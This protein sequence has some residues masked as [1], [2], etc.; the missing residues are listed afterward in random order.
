[1]TSCTPYLVGCGETYNAG[2]AC[3]Q[4]FPEDGE[5]ISPW[6]RITFINESGKE[7][8]AITVGNNSIGEEGDGSVESECS[9]AV[10]KSFVFGTADGQTAEV[11]IHDQKGSSFVQFMKNL[12]KDM[13]CAEPGKAES[14]QVKCSF[15]WVNTFCNGPNGGRAT[16]CD[17]WLWPLNVSTNFAEGK[18]M[19]TITLKDMGHIMLKHHKEDVLK[20]DDNNRVSLVEAVTQLLTEGAPSV[21]SVEFLKFNEDG[22]TSPMTFKVDESDGDPLKGPKRKW[23]SSEKDR[24][25]TALDWVS[26]YVTE[27]D[28]AI[29]PQFDSCVKGGK[30]VFWQHRHP[31]LCEMRSDEAFR[32]LCIGTFL[33][34]GGSS[35][36]VI[37]FNPNVEWT[38]WQM[39]TGGNMGTQHVHGGNPEGQEPGLIDGDC[40]SKSLNDGVYKNTGGEKS[41]GPDEHQQELWGKDSNKKAAQAQSE[42]LRAN[43]LMYRSVTADLKIIGDPSINPFDTLGKV[44]TI[45]FI[46][47]FHHIADGSDC[48]DWLAKPPCNEVLSNRGWHVQSITH[49]IEGGMFTTTL[50]VFLPQPGVD[51]AF[52]NKAGADPK[53]WAPPS[54]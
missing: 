32:N 9:T 41:H 27:E 37:E 53:G 44:A 10:I 22:T 39:P 46:N 3:P 42:H 49:R 34:N 24:L 36:N 52:G 6:V 51:L 48:G 40:G 23:P 13:A 5:M 31:K 20:G 14:I 8:N 43:P 33:V 12:L 15:G 50:Q 7:I 38:F 29:V 30:I 16:A 28:R 1:M 17:Y 26:K 35:S 4:K 25:S 21:A 47:P 11:V 45:I 19:Y 18:F 2:N 54:C